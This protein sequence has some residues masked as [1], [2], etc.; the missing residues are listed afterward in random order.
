MHFTAGY[1]LPDFV[2]IRPNLS[3]FVRF[4]PNR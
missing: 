2:R 3:D 4:R 1:I